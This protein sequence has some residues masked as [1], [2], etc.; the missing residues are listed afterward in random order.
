MDHSRRTFLTRG[1]VAGA[2][3]VAATAAL[4]TMSA[5]AMT[6]VA[7]S[8]QRA[9]YPGPLK[10]DPKGLLA[11]PDGFSYK[12]VAESGVTDLDAG[13]KTPERIDGT[14]AF[15]AGN[16]VRLV[17]NH[18]VSPKYGS[19]FPVPTTRGT[20]YDAGISVGGG[21]TVVEV[22]RGGD[23][24]REWVGLSGTISNCAG[25]VTPWGTWLT[26][27]ET[28]DR[29]GTKYGS[30]T[31]QQDHGFVFEVAPDAPAKQHPQPI[32]AWGRFAHEA[33]VVQPGG[34]HVYLTEDA[35]GRNGLLYR[36]STP[37][38]LRLR[39][40]M[41]AS[42]RPNVG[43]LEAMRVTAPDGGHLDDLSRITSQY[44]GTELAVSWV[45]VPDR[46]AEK[47]SIREQFSDSAITRS[48]KLE[49]A[50]GGDGGMWF[51]ASFAHEGDVPQSSIY[52][53][54]QL[55][56]YDYRRQTLTL[57]L[58]L[59]YVAT[60]HAGGEPLDLR[61]KGVTYFDGPDNVH[62]SPFGGIVFAEDGD[63]DQHLVGFTESGGAFPLARNEL[64]GN[65]A[66]EVSS[67]SELTGPT[68]S[69]DGRILFANIQ[70]P[71]H[72][73]AISGPFGR[74]LRG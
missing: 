4:P 29:K 46:M 25:G 72:A 40:G 9:S 43:R 48:K 71:G 27:E 47:T 45:N 3:A 23:R 12:L 31:L 66:D 15:A 24:I 49:G 61:G 11:L 60:I 64:K 70:E 42:L 17:Q 69:P 55:W 73:F 33:A 53:D 5:E 58:Y 28:E 39:G 50:W 56:F 54:G 21:C 41:L 13:G 34:A 63:G 36:W 51:A 37:P 59:P 16:R 6:P 2:G 22:T 62:V 26:C 1:A 30:Q 19:D 65:A 20:V 8:A 74:Y 38:G 67:F 10:A 7:A 44:V 68:F 14:G 35:S 57:K 18:E 32:R 52:H